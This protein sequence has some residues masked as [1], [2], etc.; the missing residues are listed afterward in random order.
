MP[1]L[2]NGSPLKVYL[3]Q[4]LFQPD[5]EPVTMVISKE[6]LRY[7]IHAV[8]TDS[9]KQFGNLVDVE[10]FTWDGDLN[11]ATKEAHRRAQAGR[12]PR[13]HR[14]KDTLHDFLITMFV[15]TTPTGVIAPKS[16]APLSTADVQEVLEAVRQHP[17][18]GQRTVLVVSEE[19][20]AITL[21]SG[22]IS[23]QKI[24]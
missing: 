7:E 13:S 3:R 21:S 9:R 10:I 5:K 15:L 18:Y 6:D 1:I 20:E 2:T 4:T 23:V 22:A 16:P 12:I 19:G 14:H 17:G 24:Q 11:S 8:A